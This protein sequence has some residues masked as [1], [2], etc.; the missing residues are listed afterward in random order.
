MSLS[1]PEFIV[2]YLASHE[3]ATAGEIAAV[4]KI[5]KADI[6]YHLAD[7]LKKGMVLEAGRTKEGGRGRPARLFKLPASDHPCAVQSLLAA[8]LAQVDSLPIGGRDS[9][10][11][12]L[13]SEAWKIK[14]FSSPS[15]AIQMAYLMTR[16]NTLGY[17]TGWDIRSGYST[18][19]F[20]A[21]PYRSL[22]EKFPFLCDLDR[23]GLEQV[24]HGK[25]EVIKTIADETSQSCIFR[26]SD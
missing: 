23:A 25:V 19:T 22:I 8:F 24:A 26:V 20:H 2:H 10:L 12:R 7:L 21:C 5:T 3:S 17:K 15:F 13:V 16:L 9:V 1:T 6:R 18:I 14:E 11:T 4:L